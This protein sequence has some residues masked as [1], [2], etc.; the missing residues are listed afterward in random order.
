VTPVVK[1]RHLTKQFNFAVVGA[2]T[3]ILFSVTN[4]ILFNEIQENES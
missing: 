1:G 2:G 4:A 3:N